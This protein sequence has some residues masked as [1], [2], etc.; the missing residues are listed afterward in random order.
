MLDD[1]KV[2]QRREVT[3]WTSL[4]EMEMSDVAIPTPFGQDSTG[5]IVLLF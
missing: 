3:S 5:F 1:H 4:H 2:L